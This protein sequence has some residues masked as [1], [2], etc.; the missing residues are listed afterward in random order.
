MPKCI[1]HRHTDTYGVSIHSPLNHPKPKFG[2]QTESKFV[3]LVVVAFYFCS[4]LVGL[5]FWL[6]AAYFHLFCCFILL[7]KILFAFLEGTKF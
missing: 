1:A 4:L 2:E 6:L 3:V 7:G 5:A